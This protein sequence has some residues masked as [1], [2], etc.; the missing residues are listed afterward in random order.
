MSTLGLGINF[1][2]GF[3]LCKQSKIKTLFLFLI[4]K[5]AKAMI[6]NALIQGSQSVQLYSMPLTYFI[7]QEV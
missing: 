4:V 3:F 7:L 5:I 2:S 1:S 6:K